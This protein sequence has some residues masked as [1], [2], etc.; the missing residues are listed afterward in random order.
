M[1]AQMEIIYF[2]V[3]ILEKT[4]SLRFICKSSLLLN[5][6]VMTVVIFFHPFL[7]LHIMDANELGVAN[8][9]LI[10]EKYS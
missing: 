7:L 8:E 2:L 6:Q 3:L 10:G 9:A 4:P 5:F 1:V